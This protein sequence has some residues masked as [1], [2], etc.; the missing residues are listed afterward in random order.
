MIKV[1]KGEVGRNAYKVSR[2][3]KLGFHIFVNA[4]DLIFRLCYLRTNISTHYCQLSVKIRKE[5]DYKIH[6]E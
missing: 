4:E 6:D 5:Y 3:W 2:V 1:R